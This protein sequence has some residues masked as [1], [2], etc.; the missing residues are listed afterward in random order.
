MGSSRFYSPFV[1]YDNSF[2]REEAMLIAP[3]VAKKVME[4]NFGCYS[5]KEMGYIYH[6]AIA[7]VTQHITDALCEKYPEESFHKLCRWS[8]TYAF[9]YVRKS[10][11]DRVVA[12]REEKQAKNNLVSAQ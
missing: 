12:E 7:M 3:K 6:H 5:T 9:G 2:D 4:N 10:V 8:H 1:K 11:H